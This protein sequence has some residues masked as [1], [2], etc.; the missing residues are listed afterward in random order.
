MNLNTFGLIEPTLRY[1]LFLGSSIQKPGF[2]VVGERLLLENRFGKMAKHS[3]WAP[4]CQ[5]KGFGVK[6]K[7]IPIVSPSSYVIYKFFI[8]FHMFFC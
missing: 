8:V 1:V 6:K 4:L 2:W 5:K 7:I 3:L